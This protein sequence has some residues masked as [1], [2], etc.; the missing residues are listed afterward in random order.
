MGSEAALTNLAFLVI[1]NALIVDVPQVFAYPLLDDMDDF[2]GS[3]RPLLLDFRLIK[4][5]AFFRLYFLD[6]CFQMAF[7][8]NGCGVLLL[9]ITDADA[10]NAATYCRA[11][12]LKLVEC[13]QE[14]LVDLVLEI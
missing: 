14:L 6:E 8:E 7:A 1:I 11:E 13:L 12:L 5:Y 3:K 10:A 4:Q 2:D 9:A